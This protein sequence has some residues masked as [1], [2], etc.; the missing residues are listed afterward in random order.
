MPDDDIPEAIADLI[1]ETFSEPEPEPTETET[2]EDSQTTDENVATGNEERATQMEDNL[3]ALKAA[4]VKAKQ[5]L[6]DLDSDLEALEQKQAQEVD[7]IT[8]QWR[9]DK[10]SLRL[11]VRDA[12]A[13]YK[14]D[15]KLAK[16]GQKE[17]QRSLRN[18][19][20]RLEKVI[21]LAE[22]ELKL[23]SNRGKLQLILADPELVGTLRERWIAAEVAKRLDYPIFMAVNERG[24][25]DNS[26][27]YDYMVDEKTGSLVEF[28]SGHPQEGQL[29]V[30]QDLVNFSLRPE[31]L[32]NAFKIPDDQICIAEA[33]V[34]FAQEQ[35]L[36]FWVAE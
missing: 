8:E 22:Y 9:G 4:L 6:M 15:L 21:P 34:R 12:E 7:F 2:G 35:K 28:P 24:G 25:K 31:Q 29:V 32:A 19:I 1:A 23:L 13:A 5:R 18:E 30:S 3:A 20:K 14:I 17:K 36:S 16:E 10:A 27:D 33:F 11:R 26:G